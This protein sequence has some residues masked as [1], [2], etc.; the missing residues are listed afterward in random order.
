MRP[1]RISIASDDTGHDDSD[2]AVREE[3]LEG[4]HEWLVRSLALL[5]GVAVVGYA[6]LALGLNVLVDTDRVR[7][8]LEPRAS[9]ALNRPVS[10]GDARVALLPRPSIHVSDVR[11]DN[12]DGVDG[13]ALAFVERVRLDVRLLP[14]ALGRVE[15]HRVQLDGPR[16]NLTVDESGTS[17]F[18]DLM[19]GPAT[20]GDPPAAPVR[21]AI[22]RLVVSNASLAYFNAPASRSFTISGADARVTLSPDGAAGWQARIDA[23]SDSLLARLATVTDE[24]I[25]MEGPEATLVARSDGSDGGIA[26]EDGVLQ[27]A[28]ETLLLSGRLTGLT[29]S[30]PA[31]DL[32]LTNEAI[33]AGVLAALLPSEFRSTRVPALDGELSVTV[34]VIAARTP[35]E[36]PLVQGSVHLSDVALH[37][38]GQIMVDRINGTIGVSPDTL[39]L[40][41]LTGEFADGPFELSGSVDRSARAVDLTIRAR[42]DLDALDRLGLVPD[43]TTLSGDAALD[44]SVTARLG[45]LDSTDIAGSI[46]L[47]GLQAKH[48]RI[49][50]PIYVPAGELTLVGNEVRWNELAVLI[51]QDQIVTS[52]RLAGLI[53][54][55]GEGAPAPTLQASLRGPRLDL[56]AAMRRPDDRPDVSYGHIAFAH[57]GGHAHHGRALAAVVAELGLSRPTSLP[58]RGEVSIEVDTLDF[59]LYH[60]SAVSA[61]IELADSSLSV[62]APSFTIWGGRT[63]SELRMGVGELREEPFSLTL[64]TAGASAE[65]LLTTLTPIGDAVSGTLTL[66]IEVA[67]SLDSRLLPV[68]RDLSG[69]VRVGIT[70]GRIHDT[71]PN[72]VV[73]DFLGSQEWS[74]V[75]FSTWDTEL[76]VISRRLEVR[77]SELTSEEG[78]VALDGHL[79]LDGSHDL[80]VAISIP[81]DRLELV[82][83]RRTGIGQS[84]LD[85]LAAAGSSLDLGLRMSGVLGAPQLEPDASNAVALRR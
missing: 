11:V 26:I 46:T 7:M 19:P 38:H 55:S 79:H 35:G 29:G 68:R 22:D 73:A 57:L 76:D 20:G 80:R 31:Y 77:S 40:D 13:A 69:H 82:S 25:R 34:Q 59:H 65:E 63:S 1:R 70:D 52:G 71:G 53:A 62:L 27:L 58:L 32:Q 4:L 21:L 5:A 33:D 12:L 67:G 41:S 47:E 30:S 83:L 36:G 3:R 42:P 39:V 10:T 81:P 49:G 50:V 66:D 85:H 14:L 54:G 51:G 2:F 48:A 18:G 72:L 23:E 64:T 45:A 15:V 9:A 75:E 78:R 44:L 6:L 60:A 84:V 8:W 61:R 37:M 56:G 43:G 28:G 74:D 17:N 24:I 16:V